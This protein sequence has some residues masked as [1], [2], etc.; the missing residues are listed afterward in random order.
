MT[1][2]PW[3]KNVLALVGAGYA[4]ILLI[5][6]LMVFTGKNAI[7]SYD[8][9]KEPL[10]AVIGGSLAISKDLIPRF[11]GSETPQQHGE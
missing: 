7:E 10:M 6:A 8:A 4:T 9:I 5:Y 1:K 11:D 3:R 2:L